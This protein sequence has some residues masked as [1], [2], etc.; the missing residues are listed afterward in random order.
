MDVTPHVAEKTRFNADTLSHRTKKLAQE[1]LSLRTLTDSKGIKL[2]TQ[3]D[4]TLLLF[5]YL[6]I[7]HAIIF[8]TLQFFYFLHKA[9]FSIL[10]CKSNH[11]AEAYVFL[12]RHFLLCSKV[13]MKGFSPIQEEKHRSTTMHRAMLFSFFYRNHVTIKRRAKCQIRA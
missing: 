9:F 13:T 11:K 6:G 8:A 2:L 3:C 12:K 10:R 1:C 4:G 5:S 7:I